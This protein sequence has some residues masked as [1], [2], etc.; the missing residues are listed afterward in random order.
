MHRLTVVW[1]GG[2]SLKA[3]IQG[4]TVELGILIITQDPSSNV[5]PVLELFG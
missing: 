2:E 1:R 4:S 5:D 3:V